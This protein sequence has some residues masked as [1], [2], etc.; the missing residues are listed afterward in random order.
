M[1]RHASAQAADPLPA[2][3]LT[4]PALPHLLHPSTLGFGARVEIKNLNSVRAVGR[5]VEGEALRQCDILERGGSVDSETR[6]AAGSAAMTALR[7]KAGAQDYRFMPEP[8][9]EPILV[10]AAVLQGLRA[11]APRDLFGIYLALAGEYGLR[12]ED[13]AFLADHARLLGAFYSALRAACMGM[14]AQAAAAGGGA[15]AGQVWVD[16]AN[17]VA[18]A[19]APAAAAAHAS[20]PPFPPSAQPLAAA[21]CHWLCSEALG[22]VGD[23]E[24]VG[25]FLARVGAG[26]P[27]CLGALVALVQA[28]VISGKSGKAVWGVC[29]E[30]LCG[31]GDSGGSVNPREIA[32]E[33]DLFLLKDADVLAGLA[34]RVC[35]EPAL[36]GARAKWEAG[37][38][39]ALGAFVAALLEASEGRACPEAASEAL[40]R[41]LGPAGGAGGEGAGLGAV[42][43]RKEARRSAAA[44]AALA[45][46]QRGL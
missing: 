33:M 16:A 5:A 45:K 43:G 22:G 17:A 15:A 12:G 29:V 19:A 41:M 32:R 27:A 37:S 6:A 8:D 38:A 25:V 23:G 18:G 4:L 13:A 3:Q 31:G 42:G 46:Q 21:V 40:V 36:A 1:G 28:G 9:I 34:A 26:A 39:R 2:P 11:A 35:A 44:A 10:P 30:R 20:S 14:Q 24:G 7:S